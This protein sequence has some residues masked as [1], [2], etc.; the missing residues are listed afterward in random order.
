MNS[1]HVQCAV[2]SAVTSS[3]LLLPSWSGHLTMPT[4]LTTLLIIGGYTS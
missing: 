1:A 2:A 4:L 3:R